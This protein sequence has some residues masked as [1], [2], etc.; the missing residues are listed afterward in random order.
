MNDLDHA[1]LLQLVSS[2]ENTRIK[3]G[4]LFDKAVAKDFTLTEWVCES[5]NVSQSLALALAENSRS[6]KTF[7]SYVELLNLTI[8]R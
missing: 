2:Y 1:K 4:E 3:G 8:Q 7:T 5:I 6:V